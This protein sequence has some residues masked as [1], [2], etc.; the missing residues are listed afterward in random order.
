MSISKHLKGQLGPPVGHVAFFAPKRVSW[1]PALVTWQEVRHWEH[2]KMYPPDFILAPRSRPLCLAAHRA[3]L[4][5]STKF[6]VKKSFDN[7][8]PE[9]KWK[10]VFCKG[11]VKYLSKCRIISSTYSTEFQK[12]V[13]ISV[14]LFSAVLTFRQC[15]QNKIQDILFGAIEIFFKMKNNSSKF[16]HCQ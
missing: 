5:Q 14:T 16:L 11:L 8:F 13:D 6:L 2:P 15:M 4:A 9:G 7:L 3:A 12:V 1:G 10:Q